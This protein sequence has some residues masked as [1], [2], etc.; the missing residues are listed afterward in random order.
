MDQLI[1]QENELAI[2]ITHY[3][4]WIID[5]ENNINIDCYV[6]NDNRRVLSLRGT[7]RAM[8]LKGG[9]SGALV[10]SLHAKWIEP[11]L[12][13]NLIKWLDDIENNRV[14]DIIGNRKKNFTPFDGDL[15]VD[16]CKAYI[17]ANNDGIFNGPQ[18]NKQKQTAERLLSVM[19][20]FAKVGIVALIDEITG[21]QEE[22]E[23]DELQKILSLYI[24]EEFMPWTK[25]FPDEFYKEIF[26]LKNWEYKGNP[27]PGIIGKITNYLVYEQLPEGVIEELRSKNPI[28]YKHGRRKYKHHQ[29]LTESTGI[30]HLDKHLASVITLMRGCDNWDE[31]DKLFRKSFDLPSQLEIQLKDDNSII[32]N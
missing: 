14:Q 5:E 20:A 7:A 12:S 22:R 21:Y 32:F 10:R 9:G 1:K 16:L 27:K 26:R 13:Q 25:R 18:W 17:Q 6:T 15:F 28:V 19:S 2:H 29:Y 8:G 4:K 23:K 3:G 31:F 30:P 24:R 11:Y